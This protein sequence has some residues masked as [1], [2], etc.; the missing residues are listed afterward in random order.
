MNPWELL[1][2]RYNDYKVFAPQNGLIQY[3]DSPNGPIAISPHRAVSEDYQC[4]AAIC[5]DLNPSN[6][7]RRSILRDGA[8]LKEHY[9][10]MRGFIAI[11]LA[12]FNRSG[13]QSGKDMSDVEFRSAAGGNVTVTL[14]VGS[15]LLPFATH[16]TD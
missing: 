15:T 4:L 2:S 1:T 8:W 13:E 6:H 10:K 12:D 14:R 7:L 5:H 16:S 11:V 3:I 9:T